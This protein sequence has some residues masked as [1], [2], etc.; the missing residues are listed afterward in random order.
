M[1]KYDLTLEKQRLIGADK[2]S[3]AA[4]ANETICLY[5]HFDRS[6]RR[7]DSKAAVFR[8]S[9]SKYYIIEIVADRAKVPWEVL[10]SE[11]E[12][13]LSVIGFESEKV[14]TSDKVEILVT[15]S[16]LPEDC[17]ILTPSEV[18][19]DRFK[20]ECTAQAYLDY[21]DEINGLKQAHMEEK[22]KLGAE[23]N[24]ANK[25]TEAVERQKNEEIIQN[26]ILYSKQIKQLNDRI[27]ELNSTLKLY[28]HKAESWDMVDHALGLK[29]SSSLALWQGGKE[30]YALPMLN[31]SSIAN[32]SSS[33]FSTNLTEIGLDLSSAKTFS[34]VFA[35]AISI[36]KVELINGNNVS[37][38]AS[39]FENCKTIKYVKIDKMKNCSNMS[40]FANEATALQTVTFGEPVEAAS[41][42]KAFANCMVLRE[43]NGVLNLTY[44]S[45]LSSMFYNCTSLAEVRFTE[46]SIGHNI[47]F[48]TCIN[49]SKES[50]I[51]I[52]RG[53]RTGVGDMLTV[54]SYA[55]ETNFTEEERDEWFSFVIE[56]KEWDFFLN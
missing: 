40:R 37:S 33:I 10:T 43:I 13:E 38:Y 56:E 51:S 42:E 12:F 47:D 46:E 14:I 55:F 41:Y 21:E 39:L 11:G 8:N 7:F 29:T 28:V 50:L 1:I 49:L 48:G 3:I 16:L 27:N 31:T 20:R 30:K 18:L 24:E 26:E 32:F 4:N 15:E 35:S 2:F 9:A 22:L 23:I 6:W 36:V 54:S 19:F 45:D 52:F 17:K 53:L 25:R 44:A 34:G 5:F